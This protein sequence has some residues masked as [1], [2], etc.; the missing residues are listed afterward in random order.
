M[1]KLLR[2][3]GF[4]D[5]ILLG[6]LF[7]CLTIIVH[8]A[9]LNNVIPLQWING[10]MSETYES[11]LP[12]SIFNIALGLLGLVYVQYASYKPSSRTVKLIA[13]V[14]SITYGLALIMQ[15]LGTPFEKIVMTP[16]LLCGLLS[17]IRLSM[18]E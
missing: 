18:N 5:A 17:H 9:V 3:I 4:E 1:R 2:K 14:L 10:G 12:L 7:Y 8:L 15:L 13:Y 11:Q 16:I 6:A